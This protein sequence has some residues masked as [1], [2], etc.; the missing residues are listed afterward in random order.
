[1]NMVGKKN[2]TCNVVLVVKN[3]I[4]YG[5]T[6]K[7]NNQKQLEWYT[8]QK[9]QTISIKNYMNMI[10]HCNMSHSSWN[11]KHVLTIISPFSTICLLNLF[12]TIQYPTNRYCVGTWNVKGVFVF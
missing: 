7:K 10:Q 9:P 11:S 4:N 6:I 8:I 5:L 3:P 12:F 2:N 1:M